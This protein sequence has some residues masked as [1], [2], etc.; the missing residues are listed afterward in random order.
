MITDALTQAPSVSKKSKNRRQ[1]SPEDILANELLKTTLQPY[2][3]QLYTSWLI[4]LVNVLLLAVQMYWLAWLFGRVFLAISQNALA[5]G[6]AMSLF[7]QALPYLVVCLLLRP[8]LMAVREKIV[9]Q[10]GLGMASELRQRLFEKLSELG[11]ARSWFGSDGAIASFV[12]DGPDAMMGYGRYYVQKL[13]A[14]TTPIVIA[15]VVATKSMTAAMLLL[16]TA[17]IV[18]V[19]MAVIGIATAKKSRAQMDAMAQMSGRFLD[20]LRGINTLTRLGAVNIASHDIAYASAEYKKRTMSVLKVAFLNSAV[21]EFFSALSIAI[22]AIYLGFGL[23]GLLP[24][25]EG[26]VLT[27]YE[28][29]L[30]ILLLVPEFYAPLR[31]LGAEYHAKGAAEGVAKQLSPMLT[32]ESMPTAMAQYAKPLEVPPTIILSNLSVTTKGRNRLKD[33]TLTVHSTQKIAIMGRS[34][35]GKSTLLQVLLGFTPYDGQ[36]MIDGVEIK[37]WDKSSMRSVMGYL[38]QTPAFL[39]MTIADN[40]R[41]A[42][43]NASDDELFEVLKDVEMYEVIQQLPKG[44]NT[45]LL[46]RGGGL[47]GGQ[48]QRLA[49]AQLL[50]QDAKVWLLDEP[51][52][53]LDP[54]TKE[55]INALFERLSR[56]K[57]VIWVT[58]DSP[59]K[60]LDRVICLDQASSLTD[61]VTAGDK[62]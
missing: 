57:T 43:P 44:I 39:P 6:M 27:S 61:I 45:Y 58:H 16:F 29:A 30:F 9:Y 37:D 56:D 52:E 50:L 24:W 15:M 22:V 2:K 35:S 25:S 42:K 26:K 10:T 41:L 32:F 36:A 55:Q 31:R 38:P 46:E 21:L 18:I 51:T 3:K 1:K 7:M 8:I 4:D 59:C 60:W 17:P 11:L 34:G 5:Q 62:Q 54:D 19:C 14:V 13:T 40:L 23:M 53:H 33:L 47:S 28:V 12:V 48:I 20:W 49:V